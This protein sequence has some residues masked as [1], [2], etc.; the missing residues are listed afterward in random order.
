MVGTVSTFELSSDAQLLSR[1]RT[2]DPS[3]F[4]SLV[5][6]HKHAM[7]NYLT[8]LTGDRDR[9]EDLAQ[10]AFLRLYAKQHQY[11]EE[12]KLTAYLYRIATNLLCS[13]NRRQRR[14]QLIR[15]LVAPP[16]A[17]QTA[18]G[19][20][21]SVV[22]DERSQRLQRAIAALPVR[23]RV[24]LVLHELEE[25][26]YRQIADLLHCR[27]G[28]VKSRIHRARGQLRLALADDLMG[29]TP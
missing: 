15:P 25:W 18:P 4:A 17:P 1:S 16:A 10:E 23:Y 7:V 2:G 12:G 3:A 14:W 21:E 28:T 20:H 9:A 22:A 24:P 5:D 11:S 26:P 29:D 27:V 6:R 13:Q 19:Q 8:R